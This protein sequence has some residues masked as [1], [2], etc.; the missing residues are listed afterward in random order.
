MV[1]DI[2]RLDA[3]LLLGFE[4]LFVERSVTRAAQRIGLTQQ[5][6][7]GQLAR[8]RDLFGDPLF[9]REAGGITPTPR[10][11]AIIPA[12]RAALKT[13]E[14]VVTAPQ[15][16][17]ANYEGELTVAASDYAI[18]LL[19]PPLLKLISIEAPALRLIV[20]PVELG[21]LEVKMKNENIDL[22]L[23]VPEF[24]PT[25]LPSQVLFREKYVGVMRKDHP[26]SDVPVT[27]DEFCAFPH[28]LV[29]PFRG[30][31][32]GPTDRALELVGRKRTIGLVVPG[33]SVVGALLEESDLIA[34]LP[35]RLMAV[36]RRELR[37]FE[38]PVPVEGFQ[39][40]AVWPARLDADPANQW[41][42]GM[43][44]RA[45]KNLDNDSSGP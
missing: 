44:N 4:A 15:F 43:I 34:V 39:L 10:A 40:E 24:A 25:A 14:A 37:Q 6:M 30:D 21:T 26:M 42:R 17:P 3:R 38:T 16:D 36:M 29:A 31:A 12:V 33:F 2:A 35:Q 13:L 23:T 7:S 5:G 11:Q 28:M 45:L 9:V 1:S 8:M 18:A 27:L 32:A 20:R 22:A 19:L 41:L